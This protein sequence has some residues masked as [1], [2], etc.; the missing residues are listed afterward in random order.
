MMGK[1]SVVGGRAVDV[2]ALP[3]APAVVVPALRRGELEV[4]LLP[5]VLADVADQQIPCRWVETEFPGVA[6]SVGPDFRA[7]SAGARRP[8]ERI[9]W[10]Y[11]V[12]KTGVHIDTQQLPQK[13]ALALP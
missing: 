6:Q 12:R 11:G 8:G 1:S 9:G 5:R 10:R 13:H 7:C 3:A 2:V 4:H